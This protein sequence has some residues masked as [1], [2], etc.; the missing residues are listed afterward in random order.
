[1]FPKLRISSPDVLRSVALLIGTGAVPWV[2]TAQN[3]DFRT[4]IQ[5]VLNASCIKCHAGANVGGGLTLDSID[6]L[7]HGGKTGAAVV[8]GDPSHSLLY[9]RLTTTDVSTR[10]PLGSPALPAQTIALI[11]AW[12]EQG[13][14][15]LPA[16]RSTSVDFVRDV[17]PILQ[18]N[19][20]ACHSGAQPKSDLR[21]DQKAAAMRGGMSGR[22]IVAGN[23]N[24]SRLIHR[25]LG[26]DGEAR[27]PFGSGFPMSRKAERA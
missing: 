19:C 3:I 9:Q 11:R 16:V 27:M 17:R 21:L 25:I 5:P 18:A 14:P 24:D 20:Y 10:M 4:Q 12:I 8:A 26:A 7:A 15:G 6:A 2:L 13:A 23:S 22:V 1:M